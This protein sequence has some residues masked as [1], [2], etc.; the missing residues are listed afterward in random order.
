[1]H[2]KELYASD[3]YVIRLDEA[4]EIIKA[5]WL[6]PVSFEEMKTGGTQL[7]VALMHTQAA[8]VVANAQLLG[9]PDAVTKEWMSAEFYKL[10][11]QTSLKMIARVLPDNVFSKIALES[12]AT[13]AEA[14][15]I[16]SFRVRN[17]LEQEA[18]EAW[19]ASE[20]CRGV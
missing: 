12:V 4:H 5:R 16:T 13:R 7:Y 10:L 17:F 1:M 2:L 15:G 14:L 11:F 8:R 20:T 6:R 3:F 19:L 18:A 9:S